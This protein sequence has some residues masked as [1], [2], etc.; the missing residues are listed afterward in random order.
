ME[1]KLWLFLVENREA[2]AKV[3]S[4]RFILASRAVYMA[5]SVVVSTNLRLAGL[6]YVGKDR[7]RG[8]QPPE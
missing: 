4:R 7:S 3:V 6:V 8:T 5:E 2:T 1:Q